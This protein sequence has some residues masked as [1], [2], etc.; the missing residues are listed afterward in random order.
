MKRLLPDSLFDGQRLLYNTA[1]VV[2][3]DKVLALAPARGD[4]TKLSGI[5]V[6]GFIDVQ[7][8]GGGGALFNSTPTEQCIA[9][10][11]S[12][13]SR[14]GSTAILPTLI[15]DSIEVMQ[16]AADATANV[17][18]DNLPGILGIHFEGPHLSIEKKGVHSPEHIRPL[19]DAEKAVLRRDD[20]GIKVITLAPENVSVEDIRYLVEQDVKVCL[21]HSNADYD[22][23]MRALDAGASGFTHLYNA[24]SPLQSRAPGMVGAALTCPESWCGLIVDGHHVHPGAAKAALASK[25][26]GK[27]MLVTD[28]MSP[29]GTDDETFDLLGA[30]VVRTGDRLNALT[31][32]LAG[33]VLDMAGAVR[34]SVQTLGVS[35]EQALKMASNYPAAFLGQQHR[36]GQLKA[37]YQADMVLLDK[38]LNVTGTWI[39][40]R[41]VFTP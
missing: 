28:A 11:I 12:T 39:A 17:I 40:G 35:L 8:N 26:E 15:T 16:R 27:I 30:K 22:Q 18:K 21:G 7:V 25:P 23:T 41:Q 29:V 36:L 33:S 37:G 10:I 14:F 38:A 13:H 24:M 31:G 19:S 6:P 3:G 20:L 5:L 4:E 34:N 1:V 9:Q 32:E 2:D